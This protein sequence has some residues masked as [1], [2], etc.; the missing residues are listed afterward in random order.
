MA[1]EQFFGGSKPDVLNTGHDDMIHDAQ[2]DYYGRRLATCS[3]DQAIRIFDIS[4]PS[5][6]KLLTELRGHEGPVWQVAWAHPKFGSLLASCSYD[7][8][9]IVWREAPETPNVWSKVYEYDRHDSSVNAV[10]WAPHELG[11]A[12]ACASA[13]GHISVHTH[14]GDDAWDVQKIQAHQI[15]CN[16]VSWGP[17]VPAGSLVSGDAGSFSR[18]LVSAGCDGL[19]VIWKFD[20]TSKNWVREDALQGHT[21]WV[22]DVAWAPSIGL[23][24]STIASCSQDRKVIIWT[25]DDA[26]PWTSKTLPVFPACV[27]RVSWSP[28]GNLLAV[29]SGDNKVSLWKEGIDGEWSNISEVEDA[30]Q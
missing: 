23:P 27:W 4:D 25:R 7:H 17:A 30:T 19:V 14:R 3:S 18:R 26:S 6:E 15:G 21:D 13:D 24:S 2:P 28:T 16:A 5:Q 9:V 22:R 1:Q 8:K 20:E 12:F 29:A 10:A 11:L